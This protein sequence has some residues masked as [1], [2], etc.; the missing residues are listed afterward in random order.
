MESWSIIVGISPA[1]Y[2]VQQ[3]VLIDHVDAPKRPPGTPPP[4]PPPP[5]P[6]WLGE[7]ALHTPKRSPTPHRPT[8]IMPR[9]P[10]RVRRPSWT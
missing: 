9:S 8:P 7:S 5:P 3:Q 1:S 2:D 10:L 4:P 6:H